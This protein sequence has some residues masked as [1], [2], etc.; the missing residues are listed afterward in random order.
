MKNDKELLTNSVLDFPNEDLDPQIWRHE[1]DT[2]VLTDEADKTIGNLV[3]H[4]IETFEIPHC[5]VNITGSITSNCYTK[6]ADIDVHFLSPNIKEGKAEEF[7][8]VLREEFRF[9]SET[10]NINIGEHPL[11]V[12]FQPNPYGDFMSVGCYN[13]TTKTW[14][15]GPDLTNETYN[16]YSDY[17]AD[18]QRTAESFIGEI[19]SNILETYELAVTL[20]NMEN[21]EDDPY[22]AI[23]SSFENCL[24]ASQDLFDLVR[25]S[26][27][28]MS[29]PKSKEDALRKR[30][31]RRWHIADATFKMMDKY[32]YMS[33]LW[34]YADAIDKESID[35][36]VDIVMNAI[37]EN[38]K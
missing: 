24:V 11:E 19:R 13:Y 14:E 37:K 2:Y 8:K 32:G 26:R 12:Y 9:Y 15:V 25:Q 22:D 35:E 27:A 33:V 30:D 17:Y 1:G 31:S 5:T 18:I 23:A 20:K 4:M 21:H 6:T 10:N 36:K 28:V 34:N 38:L 7:T 29:A 16:P 3:N